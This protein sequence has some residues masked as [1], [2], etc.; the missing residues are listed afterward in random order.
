[1]N[2]EL[3]QK[4]IQI[5]IELIEECLISETEDAAVND[6]VISVVHNHIVRASNH[7]FVAQEQLEEKSHDE[8]Q[9]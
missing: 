9:A 5:A 6:E 7:L 3:L 8:N 1:M 2:R 4:R